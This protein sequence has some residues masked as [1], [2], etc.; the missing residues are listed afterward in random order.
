MDVPFPVR[1]AVPMNEKP[2]THEELRDRI[3]PANFDPA[4]V[5]VVC[6]IQLNPPKLSF[7]AVRGL[8]EEEYLALVAEFEQRRADWIARNVELFGREFPGHHCEHCGTYIK[9][10]ICVRYIPTGQ[11]FVV[12][13]TCADERMELGSRAA[14]EYRLLKMSLEHRAEQ[15][16]IA[17]ARATFYREHP[18]EAAFLLDPERGLNDFQFSLREKLLKYGELTPKQLACVTRDAER[19]QKFEAAKLAREEALADAP[20]LVE[21]RQTIVGTIR[22]TKWADGYYDGDSVLKILVETDEGNRV[23]GTCPNAIQ[24][25]FY[26]VLNEW[27]N[28]KANHPEPAPQLKGSRVQFDAKVQPKEDHFGF[29]SRP[30]KPQLV[31]L[32]REEN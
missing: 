32:A 30:T 26:A 11:H 4:D 25:G 20:K 2:L 21:G 23:F 1:Y 29:Y 3:R 5:E 8:P 9:Y 7:E 12:G 14:H 31:E 6:A 22:S 19:E 13:E 28:D 17:A 15:A 18:V 27:Q 10:G 16:R 24:D